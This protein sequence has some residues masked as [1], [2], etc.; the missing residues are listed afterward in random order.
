RGAQRPGQQAP[1]RRV[2]HAHPPPGRTARG[3]RLPDIVRAAPAIGAL[4]LLF[5]GA[6]LGAVRRSLFPPG[7]GLDLAPW[8]QVLS[9]PAL[10]DAGR[11]SLTVTAFATLIAALLAVPIAAALRHQPLVRAAFALPVLVP[12]LVIAVTAVAWLGPGGLADRLLGGLPFELVR[13]RAGAGIVLVYVYK[14]L[15]FLVL[16]L[17]AGW[18]RETAEREEAAAMLGAGRLQRFRWIVWPAVR[19][20]LA[21]GSLIVAAYVLGAFEVPLVVGP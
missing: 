14:E 13:D 20:P 18:D 16:L 10:A 9:D 8:R 15:P 2:E 11:F 21:T 1:R 3:T 19:T 6:L 5:G 17:V 7:G 12:H 4:L